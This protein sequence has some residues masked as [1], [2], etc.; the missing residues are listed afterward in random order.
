[1]LTNTLFTT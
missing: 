1:M